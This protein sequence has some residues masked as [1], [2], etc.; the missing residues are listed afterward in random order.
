MEFTPQFLLPMETAIMAD[1]KSVIDETRLCS[2]CSSRKACISRDFNERETHMFEHLT[3]GK[4]RVLRDTSLYRKHD[5]LRMLYI[6]R[7]GQFKLIS[8]NSNGKQQVVGF[9]MAG[10]LMGIDMIATGLHQF[11]VVALENSEVCEIPFSE[12]TDMMSVEPAI[13]HGFF[14]AMSVSLNNVYS[15][16]PFLAKIALDARFANF[17]LM[18][19][20][21]YGRLGYSQKSFRLSMS[22]G[23]IGS[24]LGISIESVSRLISRFNAQGAV[25][26]NGRMVELCDRPYLQTLTS[27][28]EQS[29][30]RAGLPLAS[31]AEGNR[32]ENELHFSV[33]NLRIAA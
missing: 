31:N 9:Y 20:E 21:K 11:R 28:D 10:D 6:V 8:E 7:Y 2:S 33:G 16:S 29:A 15:R 19:G 26:V 4:R 12:A 3:A 22:R 32:I 17:L 5:S 30:K 1:K 27:G 13:Q 14:Q 24:Y 18:L 23:D 25:S